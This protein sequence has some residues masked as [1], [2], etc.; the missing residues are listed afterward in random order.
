MSDAPVE[1]RIKLIF[2]PEGAA[3]ERAVTLAREHFPVLLH[4]H[5]VDRIIEMGMELLAKEGEVDPETCL[6]R[7]GSLLAHLESDLESMY[8][9][10]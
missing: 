6:T 7:M 1:Y 5:P 10:G 4:R 3:E 8:P 9:P 2:S